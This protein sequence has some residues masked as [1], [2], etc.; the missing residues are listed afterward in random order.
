MRYDIL[1]M[2]TRG[3]KLQ[4]RRSKTKQLTAKQQ[5]SSSAGKKRAA[6]TDVSN[7]LTGKHP[8]YHKKVDNTIHQ[9]IINYSLNRYR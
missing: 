1:R 8:A 6:L 3:A 4:T 7:H 5:G 9:I 2:T